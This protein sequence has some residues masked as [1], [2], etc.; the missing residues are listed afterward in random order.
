MG[1]VTRD[2]KRRLRQ[3]QEEEKEQV[4]V[5]RISLLPDGVLEDI[6]SLLPTK[7]AARTQLL[8]SRWRGGATSGA[9]L[10]ST[11]T[12]TAT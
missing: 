6:V 9:P 7:D 8:S 1:V 2:K 10:P 3:L 5:D 12:S 4:L 11:S